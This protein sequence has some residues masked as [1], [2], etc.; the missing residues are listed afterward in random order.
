MKPKYVLV[1]IL[2][3]L[4]LFSG[5]S[6]VFQSGRRSDMEKIEALE[7]ELDALRH[8]RDILEERLSQEI[9]DK[10]VSLK[11]EEKGLVI[12]FVAEVLF[13]SGK[14]DLRKESYPIL[15]KVV[16]IL[17][18]E[19]PANNIGI[20]GHTD[21]EP[22]KHSQWKSNWELSSHRALSVLHYLEKSGIDAR[23]LS[24]IGYGEYQPVASNDASE[25]RRINRRVEVVILPLSKKN[26]EKKPVKAMESRQEEELK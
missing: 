15:D 5:C 12:T 22:I 17:E 21:N 1:F 3:G 19:V 13:D 8:T 18:E 10:Q 6:I 24:A 9:K 23:R 14:S 25:G 2:S 4:L 7:K 26:I 20:E 16:R 11:M